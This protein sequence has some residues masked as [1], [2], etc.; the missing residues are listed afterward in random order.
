MLYANR[1]HQDE[2]VYLDSVDIVELV[3]LCKFNNRTNGQYKMQAVDCSRQ[4]FSPCKR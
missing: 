1:K 3:R 4:L 2:I